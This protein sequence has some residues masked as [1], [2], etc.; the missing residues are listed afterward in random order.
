MPDSDKT[1]PAR[2]TVTA[3]AGVVPPAPAKPVVKSPYR[4]PTEIVPGG[5][6]LR[7]TTIRQGKHYGGEI[8]D[9]NGNVLATFEPDQENTGNPDDGQKPGE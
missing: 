5:R 9:A 8:A 3:P 2:S 6:Y 1:T 7:R 4:S